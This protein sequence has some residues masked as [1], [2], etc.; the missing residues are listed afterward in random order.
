[1]SHYAVTYIAAFLIQDGFCINFIF[2][3]IIV[4][5]FF[6]KNNALTTSNYF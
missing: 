4:S 6:N 3:N 5:A 2:N 1:M